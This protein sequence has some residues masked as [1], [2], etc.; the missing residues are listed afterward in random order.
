MKGYNKIAG[1]KAIV[2]AKQAKDFIERVHRERKKVFIEWALP[3]F[4]ETRGRKHWWQF[5][6]TPLKHFETEQS[7][8][9]LM[10]QFHQIGYASKIMIYRDDWE[11]YKKIDPMVREHDDFGL[12][13]PDRY[14][15][16]MDYLFYKDD[17]LKYAKSILNRVND[18]DDLLLDAQ[19]FGRLRFLCEMEFS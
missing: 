2:Y 1:D 3:Y 5:W 14:Y 8:W 17:V 10:V 7:F 12:L 19:E 16:F 18:E 4:R 13:N 11:A 15:G 9:K 6:K